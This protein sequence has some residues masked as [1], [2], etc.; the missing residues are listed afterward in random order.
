MVMGYNKVLWP[1]ACILGK[2]THAS[3][4]AM[5]VTTGVICMHKSSQGKFMLTNNLSLNLLINY[6]NFKF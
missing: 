1:V 2:H 6:I 5:M 4:F 3:N